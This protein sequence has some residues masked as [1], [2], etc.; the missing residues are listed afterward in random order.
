M[1]PA[2]F[3][4]FVFGLTNLEVSLIWGGPATADRGSIVAITDRSGRH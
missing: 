4:V 2:I 1:G 3:V